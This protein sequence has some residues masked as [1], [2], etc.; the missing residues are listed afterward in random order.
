MKKSKKLKEKS[1]F[2]ST[3]GIDAVPFPIET[4]V[5]DPS[6][7]KSVLERGLKRM[8]HRKKMI[9]LHF[10]KKHNLIKFFKFLRKSSRKKIRRSK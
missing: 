5:T 10:I 3:Y 4:I 9:E 8:R 6:V 1:Y 7:Y 2:I